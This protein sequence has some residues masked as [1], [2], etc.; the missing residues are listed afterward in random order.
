LNAIE[1]TKVVIVLPDGVTYTNNSYKP[2]GEIEFNDRTNT[3]VWAIPLLEGLIGRAVPLSEL[4][5]QIAITPGA[6]VRGKVVPFVQSIQ[7]TGTDSFT[8]IPLQAGITDLPTTRSADAKN[9][10]VE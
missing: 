4:N 8:D 9:G 10:D 6:N 7:V 2:A 5:M 3:I 1:Q